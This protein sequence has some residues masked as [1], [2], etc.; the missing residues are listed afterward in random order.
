MFYKKLAVIKP[1]VTIAICTFNRD[2]YLEKCL[3][4]LIK[5][6]VDSKPIE[7]MVIN[8][9]STDNTTIIVERFQSEYKNISYYNE[10]KVGLSHARNKA[11]AKA[12]CDIIAFLDDDVK[13]SDTYLDRLLWVIDNYSFDCLGGGYLPWYLNEKPKWIPEDFGRKENLLDSI[14]VLKEDYVTGLNMIFTKQILNRIG[15]FPVKLG[16]IGNNIGYGEDDY[17]Q[18]Q[19]RKLGGVILFDPE[20][21]VYHAVLEQKQHLS[22]QLVSIFINAQSNFIIHRKDEGFFTLSFYFLKSLAAGIIKRVPFGLY[23]FIF[24]NDFF[25][26]NYIIFVL[27]PILITLG[28]LKVHFTK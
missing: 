22:W 17:V 28:R 7:V 23:R 24:T 6:G 18:F 5:Y 3:N 16:M 1:I 10:K 21:Y 8:N 25:Y 2:F 15:G 4:S 26:Q 19:I 9:N 14:G 20:L 12:K 27:R 13:I 11:L